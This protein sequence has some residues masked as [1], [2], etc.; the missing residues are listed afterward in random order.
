MKS[1]RAVLL[2]AVAAPLL[3]SAQGRGG[4][5]AS[6]PADVLV[7]KPARVF[8]GESL[9]EGWAVRVKGA[10]I[11]AVGPASSIAADTG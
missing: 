10:R 5:A 8:D 9:H 4:R 7:L 1:I 6:G 3:V 11:D 2:V